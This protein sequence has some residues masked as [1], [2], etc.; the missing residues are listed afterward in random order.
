MQIHAGC[1]PPPWT[2]R[3][4]KAG[5]CP[6]L[7][8]YVTLLLTTGRLVAYSRE[9]RS[10]LP[11]S[12]C[13]SLCAQ[14]ISASQLLQRSICFLTCYGAGAACTSDDEVRERV[15]LQCHRANSRP[16][17]SVVRTLSCFCQR[18]SGQA[19]NLKGHYFH[20]TPLRIRRQHSS[21][22][23]RLSTTVEVEHLFYF[24]R[25]ALQMAQPLSDRSFHARA[26]L[27]LFSSV[28]DSGRADRLQRH[29]RAVADLPSPA[30]VPEACP[31][32]VLSPH[33]L[34][35]RCGSAKLAE[36]YAGDS[37]KAGFFD[38]QS[39]SVIVERP[40]SRLVLPQNI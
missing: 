9:W 7:Q 32:S 16:R 18:L 23:C 35:G 39:Q 15:V 19:G 34:F 11:S 25:D 10:V 5:I 24:P 6:F 13:Q 21:V 38:K 3:T 36:W 12:K 28:A 40:P 29:W 8:S 27:A 14:D 17:D 33:N 2:V 26:W 4:K 37:H 30:R 20:L 31:L 1:R 22:L